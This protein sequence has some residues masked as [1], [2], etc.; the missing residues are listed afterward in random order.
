MTNTA[1]NRQPLM[2]SLVFL[3]TSATIAG[4]WGFEIIGRYD[5]CAL[6]LQQRIP[7]YAVIAISLVALIL[8]LTNT[9]PPLVKWLMYACAATMIIGACMGVY[10]SGVEWHWWQGPSG[11]SST[12]ILDAGKSVLPDFSRKIVPCNEAA[13][14]IFGISLAGYNALIAAALAAISFCAARKG[15]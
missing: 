14:R 1:G 3:I 6:C 8:T 10:H 5:P 12:G 4:A 11:C 2:I 15:S 13:L 7:Y 9:S